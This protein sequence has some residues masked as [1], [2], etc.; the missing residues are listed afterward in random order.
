MH[1]HY[2]HLIVKIVVSKA[3]WFLVPVVR[4]RGS[5]KRHINMHKL[6]EI[7][8]NRRKKGAA[9]GKNV[10]PHERA[11]NSEHGIKLKIISCHKTNRIAFG[12]YAA[13]FLEYNYI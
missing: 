1:W 2:F 12:R 8:Y 6:I 3:D 4:L 7:P 13:S 9:H 5:S 11:A 10:L